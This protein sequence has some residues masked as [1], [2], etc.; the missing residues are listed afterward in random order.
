MNSPR[1]SN[2]SVDRLMVP[3]LAIEK[4]MTASSKE[5][6]K[7]SEIM[8][9]NLDDMPP[10]NHNQ[11]IVATGISIEENDDLKDVRTKSRIDE[12]ELQQDETNLETAENQFTTQ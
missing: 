8:V 10:E 5:R 3:N 6:S 4:M 1:G 12:S 9:E 2:D 7:Q 11:E